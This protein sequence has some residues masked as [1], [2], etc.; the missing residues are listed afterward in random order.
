MK[1]NVLN[2]SRYQSTVYT[3]G[4]LGDDDGDCD[5]IVATL[6]L[7]LSLSVGVIGVRG[8]GT[9]ALRETNG[10]EKNGLH[11]PNCSEHSSDRI[12]KF[13]PSSDRW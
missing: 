5:S 3:Y 4:D 6:L 12:Q 9:E 8:N 13:A 7:T 11:C 2:I 1:F 10:S